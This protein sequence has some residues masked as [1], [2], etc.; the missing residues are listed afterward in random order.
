MFALEVAK[1]PSEESFGY[2]VL[3]LLKLEIISMSYDIKAPPKS[4][5]TSTADVMHTLD[6]ILLLSVNS[7]PLNS[8]G[9]GHVWYV[10]QPLTQHCSGQESCVRTLWT[11][12]TNTDLRR[13]LLAST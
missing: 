8:S 3:P 10:P 4:Q 12:H 1:S 11:P 5:S 6:G 7:Y 13:M 9:T 2:C